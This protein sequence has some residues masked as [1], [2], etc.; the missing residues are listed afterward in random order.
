MASRKKLIAVVDFMTEWGYL[1][2]HYVESNSMRRHDEAY[3][4]LVQIYPSQAQ[5]L[6]SK[7]KELMP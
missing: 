4:I 2:C 3:K 7:L 1:T 6:I 5:Y